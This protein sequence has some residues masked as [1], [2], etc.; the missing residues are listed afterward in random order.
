MKRK[1]VQI[2]SG[3]EGMAILCNDGTMWA[4]E[5]EQEWMIVREVPQGDTAPHYAKLKSNYDISLKEEGLK[6]E[7]LKEVIQ[8]MVNGFR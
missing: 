7:M 2:C 8:D 4:K 5:W 3:K 1:P 6:E